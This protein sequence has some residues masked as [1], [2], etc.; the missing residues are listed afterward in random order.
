MVYLA[1]MSRHGRHNPIFVFRFVL[2]NSCHHRS[3]LFSC[4]TLARNAPR[5]CSDVYA[6]VTYV[7]ED[8][9]GRGEL[10]VAK[11]CYNPYEGPNENPQCELPL[12]A[13]DFLY[14]HGQPD[15]DGFFEGGWL[16][17]RNLSEVLLEWNLLL[18]RFSKGQAWM[19]IVQL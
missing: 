8:A 19:F 1:I 17:S 6:I 9:D 11:Y 4:L 5:R 10:F 2:L 15:E 14:I 18:R 13:G 16:P 3:L 7:P 12:V